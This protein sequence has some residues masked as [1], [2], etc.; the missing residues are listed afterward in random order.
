M[1]LLLV[2]ISHRTAPVELRERLDFQ[3]R[4][5]SRRCARWPRREST[6]EAVVL[7]TC[8]RAEIYAVCDDLGEART[9]LVSFIC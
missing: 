1:H 8:N 2:G 5:F 4:G 9:D 3:A 7:S 6:S